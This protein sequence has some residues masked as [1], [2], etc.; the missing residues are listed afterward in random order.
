M[1]IMIKYLS[2]EKRSLDY[3][4][5]D[6]TQQEVALAVGTSRASISMIEKSALEKLRKALFLKH[7][8]ASLDDLL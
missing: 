6:A 1:E 2:T 7:D 8:I 3:L 4:D 5:Y